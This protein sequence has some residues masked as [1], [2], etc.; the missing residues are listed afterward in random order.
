VPGTRRMEDVVSGASPSPR[1]GRSLLPLIAFSLVSGLLSGS[2]AVA[3]TFTKTDQ[4]DIKGKLDIRSVTVSHTPTGAVA[5]RFRTYDGWKSRDLGP[6]RSFFI[7]Q[8]DKN[9]DHKYERCAF[10]FFASGQLR[11]VLSNC[12][13]RRI[14][15]LHVEKLSG[16][17]AKVTIPKNELTPFYWWAGV[18]V[19]SGPKPCAN[20][21]VDFAPNRFPD[22]LHDLAPPTVSMATGPLRIWKVSTSNTFPFPFSLSDVGHSGV[23]RWRV[24]AQ[25]AGGSLW[26]QQAAGT[27]GGP[28]SPLITE[29]N[30]SRNPYRVVAIDKQ[31][32]R[33]IGATRLVYVP[34]DDT[35]LSSEFSVLPPATTPDGTAFGESYSLMPATSVFTHSWT[36]PSSC[37]FEL[38]GPGAGSGLV[39]NITVTPNNGS[40]STFDQSAVPGGAR[41]TVYSDTSCS[42]TYTVTVNSGAFGLDAVLG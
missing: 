32:N 30:P 23:A 4:N 18:S 28:K 31:G 39:W 34:I 26:I 21:C 3:H 38:V 42:T 27:G 36:P 15:G 25:L 37:L 41:Q 20:L 16:T 14:R 12:G 17:T 24:E 5:Y 19:W 40:P 29:V 9:Q 8:I 33:R 35:A 11:G 6:Q 2:P 1:W 13:R 7:I 10:I 22:I